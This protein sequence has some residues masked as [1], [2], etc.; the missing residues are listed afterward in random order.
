MPHPRKAHGM[1]VFP[2]VASEAPQVAD[3]I[4]HTL[5]HF[6]SPRE[7]WH[8]VTVG[9]STPT[10]DDFLS[11]LQDLGFDHARFEANMTYG[12]AYFEGLWWRDG[13]RSLALEMHDEAYWPRYH[14]LVNS[15]GHADGWDRCDRRVRRFTEVVRRGCCFRIFADWRP[16][17]SKLWVVTAFEVESK[18]ALVDE[19]KGAG[20]GEGFGRLGERFAAGGW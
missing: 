1:T 3:A 19:P 7:L 17:S 11:D 14:S 13:G 15:A 20:F 8:E 6:A 18:R 12:S 16:S 2:M 10:L 5:K 9:A 4:A